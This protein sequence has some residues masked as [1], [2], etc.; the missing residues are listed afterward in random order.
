M[1]CGVPVLT[2]ST[3]ALQEIAGGYAQ[4][5][6]PMD[7]GSIAHGIAEIATNPARRAELVQ[8]GRRRADDFSWDRAARQTLKVYAEALARP[9]SF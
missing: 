6:D 8:L 7:V 4:L 3:S 9:G 1:A 2:S 5:V